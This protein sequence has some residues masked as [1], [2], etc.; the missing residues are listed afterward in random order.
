MRLLTEKIIVAGSLIALGWILYNLYSEGP[1]SAGGPTSRYFPAKLAQEVA[2][3]SIIFVGET[4][5]Y[6]NE[7]MQFR[8]KMFIELFDQGFDTIMIEY[9]Q[10]YMQHVDQYMQTGNEAFLAPTAKNKF[11]TKP[12]IPG[13]ACPDSETACAISEN[14]RKVFINLRQHALASGRPLP[15]MVGLDYDHIHP[16]LAFAALDREIRALKDKNLL[17]DI[18]KITMELMT[19]EISDL[20]SAATQIQAKID[21]ASQQNADV[22]YSRAVAAADHLSKSLHLRADI[23][24]A[25]SD[26]KL[27]EDRERMMHESI[28]RIF[29]NSPQSKFII[30][31]HVLHASKNSTSIGLDQSEPD[32][33]MW[34]SIGTLVHHAHPHDTAFIWMVAGT[35]KALNTK[36]G[37]PRRTPYVSNSAMQGSLASSHLYGVELSRGEESFCVG[38]ALPITAALKE[39]TDLIV[40]YPAHSLPEPVSQLAH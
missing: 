40:Y 38:H 34:T 10:A 13:F 28:T 18:N 36:S 21:L 5:H 33:K 23:N 32:R 29:S 39:Q 37:V 2:S 27:R 26:K 1:L 30:S 25:T 15:K 3:K 19:N 12:I 17:A 20:V 16:Q 24:A 22:D 11:A 14:F 4:D 31:A 8:E 6:A 9:G 35:G 7:T